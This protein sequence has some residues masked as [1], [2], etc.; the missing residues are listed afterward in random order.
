MRYGALGEIVFTDDSA[1]DLICIRSGE[2]TCCGEFI[3]YYVMAF[4]DNIY[5]NY[6]ENDSWYKIDLTKCEL[7]PIIYDPKKEDEVTTIK[8]VKYRDIVKPYM[9]WYDK[10][11]SETQEPTK[12]WY[13]SRVKDLEA[14]LAMTRVLLKVTTEKL[15]SS[16]VVAG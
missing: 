14:Q 9:K 16:G 4:P 6:L 13:E 7:A 1:V 11:K 15:V 8:E 12:E 3:D 2:C 10:I 5:R